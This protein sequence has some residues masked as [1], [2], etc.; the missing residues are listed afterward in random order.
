MVVLPFNGEAYFNFRRPCFWFSG[1]F[2]CWSENHCRFGQFF[3]NFF[4][5]LFSLHLRPIRLLQAGKLLDSLFHLGGAQGGA[6]VVLVPTLLL[7][8]T[9]CLAQLPLLD[10]LA[11]RE[12]CSPLQMLWTSSLAPSATRGGLWRMLDQ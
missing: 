6:L 4:E 5:T 10:T 7:P 1:W 8:P 2:C 3:W 12:G 9:Y 11:W